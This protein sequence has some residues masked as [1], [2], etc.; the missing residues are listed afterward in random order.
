MFGHAPVPR[1]VH[2][3]RARSLPP[4]E[5]WLSGG[6]FRPRPK[7]P[8]HPPPPKSGTAAQRPHPLSDQGWQPIR[9]GGYQPTQP[10]PKVMTPPKGGTGATSPRSGLD[11][12]DLLELVREATPGKGSDS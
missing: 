2:T 8:T 12:S 10:T 5:R 7:P 11:Y 9:K 1:S 3:F 6:D 4:D